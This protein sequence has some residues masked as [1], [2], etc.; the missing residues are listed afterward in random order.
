[1]KSNSK[2]ERKERADALRKEV[3]EINKPSSKSPSP[4]SK[5]SPADFIRRRMGEMGKK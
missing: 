2:D 3:S 4:N 5:E 1:M